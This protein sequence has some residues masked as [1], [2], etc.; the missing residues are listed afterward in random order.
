MDPRDYHYKS[1]ILD[2][3]EIDFEWVKKTDSKKLLREAIKIIQNEGFPE[4]LNE[5]EKK[6]CKVDPEYLI[7]KKSTLPPDINAKE[8]AA[9]QLEDFIKL[10]EDPKDI[11][12]QYK[13]KHAAEIERQKGNDYLRS[14]EYQE[15]LKHYEKSIQISSESSTFSN[16]A[17]AHLRLKQY[18]K[19]ISASTRSIDID[20]KNVKAFYRRGEA[21]M[22]VKNYQSAFN[23]YVK[24]CLLYTSP[25]PRDS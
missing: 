5:V 20:N 12:D 15:A 10:N 16:M 18:E 2:I 19:A 25:S 17:L 7:Y 22:A 9:R 1:T 24:S 21:F 6:L 8:E 11:A 14:S 3:N 4:L 23:D 13:I